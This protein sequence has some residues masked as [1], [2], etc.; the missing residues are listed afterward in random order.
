MG[1]SRK[2]NNTARVFSNLSLNAGRGGQ[3]GIAASQNERNKVQVQRPLRTAENQENLDPSRFEIRDVDGGDRDKFQ[4][5][6]EYVNDVFDYAFE[7]E[8][9]V[10]VPEDFLS[11]GEVTA[12]HRAILI[13]RMVE[14]ADTFKLSPEVTYMTV[15]FIDKYLHRSRTATK[16]NLHAIGVTAMWTA[17][18][19]EEVNCPVLTDFEYVTDH[20]VTTDQLVSLERD[21]LLKL[22]FDTMPSHSLLFLRRFSK[23]GGVSPRKHMIAKYLMELSFIESEFSSILPSKVAASALYLAIRISGFPYGCWDATLVHY[24]RYVE[25]DLMDL[26]E[27]FLHLLKN[28]NQPKYRGVYKKFSSPKFNRVACLSELTV[29]ANTLRLRSG[30]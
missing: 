25:S 17:C 8:E 29:Q 5:S 3:N 16:K 19:V 7:N 6:T 28:A 11:M 10:L 23:I 30:R 22:D 27:K 1:D 9:R 26:A 15:I 21:M 13:E 20:E 24:S 4:Y 12:R 14:V 2:V 18:K